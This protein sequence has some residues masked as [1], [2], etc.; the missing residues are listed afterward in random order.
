VIGYGF[1]SMA[2]GVRTALALRDLPLDERRARLQ[3]IDRHGLIATPLNSGINE[4]VVEAARRSLAADGA[5]ARIRYDGT[6]EVI[7][8]C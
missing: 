1:E 3:E 5:A 7:D 4:L 8:G 6:P 2:T